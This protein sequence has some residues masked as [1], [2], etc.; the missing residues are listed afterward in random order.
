MNTCFA[1]FCF[2][3]S[4]VWTLL[5]MFGRGWVEQQSL[6]NPHFLPYMSKTLSNWLNCILF[7][8]ETPWVFQC[9]VLGT[10]CNHQEQIFDPHE[11]NPKFALDGLL[12]LWIIQ[13]NY[14]GKGVQSLTTQIFSP[15]TIFSCYRVITNDVLDFKRM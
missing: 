2:S 13:L 11:R 3:K 5:S 4:M 9:H 14:N 12:W 10:K 1:S 6:N 8:F 15:Q 7:T